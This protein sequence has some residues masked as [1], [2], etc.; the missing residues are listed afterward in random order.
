MTELT[1]DIVR[2]N[3]NEFEVIAVET[4]HTWG[5]KN[6]KNE[7]SISGLQLNFQGLRYMQLESPEDKRGLGRE[8]MFEEILVGIFPTLMKM[9]NSWI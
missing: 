5:G 1:L 8:T 9:M 4:I 7:R 6:F 2:E 3:I